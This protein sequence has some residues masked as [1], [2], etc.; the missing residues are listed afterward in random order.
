MNTETLSPFSLACL[1]RVVAV[2]IMHPETQEPLV[3]QGNPLYP[4]CRDALI[5]AGADEVIVYR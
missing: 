5:D 4:A 2:T 3:M 1:F